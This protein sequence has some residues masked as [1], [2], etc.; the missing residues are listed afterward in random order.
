MEP[1]PSMTKK[2]PTTM[3]RETLLVDSGFFIALLDP[4]DR[5]H[6]EAGKKE[7]WLELYSL[8]VPWP[9]LYETV[10]TRFTRRLTRRPANIARFENL[11]LRSEPQTIRLDD[12]SYRHKA[13]ADTLVRAK[14]PRGSA[15][16]LVD[17][18]LHAIIEDPEVHIDAM[19]T[20]NLRD[21]GSVCQ[22]N[23]VELL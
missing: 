17:S 1:L 5:Y 18:I 11:V 23:R 14:E 19:L 3:R 22:S 7:E 10:N 8:I 4:R 6:A 16:S 20:F 12:S 21:F 2:K 13:Y 9:V 15:R